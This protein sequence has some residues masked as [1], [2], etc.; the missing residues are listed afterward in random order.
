MQ[1]IYTLTDAVIFFTRSQYFDH[2]SLFFPSQSAVTR[3]EGIPI[4]VVSLLDHDLVL[5]CCGTAL[6]GT[7]TSINVLLL[8]TCL[9]HCEIG[10]VIL[11]SAIF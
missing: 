4:R 11:N 7:A 3:M 5:Y 6:M 2:S 1:G 9:T 8:Y 10:I